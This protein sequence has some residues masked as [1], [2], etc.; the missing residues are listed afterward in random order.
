MSPVIIAQL[1]A[2]LIL[3][4]IIGTVALILAVTD[5]DSR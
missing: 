5:R 4:G 2:V 1:F 3:G